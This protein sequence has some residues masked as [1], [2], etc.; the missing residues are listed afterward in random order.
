MF[1]HIEMN[2]VVK[3]N[4]MIFFKKIFLR[5]LLFAKTNLFIRI[6]LAVKITKVITYCV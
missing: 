6:I 3:M 1:N 2:T 5:I 4:M